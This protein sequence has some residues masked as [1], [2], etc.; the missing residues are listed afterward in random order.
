[1]KTKVEINDE[2]WEH[3]EIC[4]RSHCNSCPIKDCEYKGAI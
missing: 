3:W 4:Q 2:R 1:M